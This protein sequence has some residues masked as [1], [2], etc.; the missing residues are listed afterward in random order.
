MGTFRVS[1]L[2][3]GSLVNVSK[4]ALNT[5]LGGISAYNIFG[6]SKARP[7]LFVN[8]HVVSLVLGFWYHY[9]SIG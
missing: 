5:P 7:S 6:R 4:V 2:A 3:I 1:V 8:S 9:F